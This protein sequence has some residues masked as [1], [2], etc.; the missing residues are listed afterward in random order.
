MGTDDMETDQA[1]AA[2]IVPTPSVA[3]PTPVV[4]APAV[5]LSS[6]PRHQAAYQERWGHL[7][8]ILSGESP[9]GLHLQV[10]D[11]AVPIP[12]FSCHLLVLANS[13]RAWRGLKP[14]R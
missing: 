5:T 14:Q 1:A 6:E 8:Q 7:K 9:I 13:A 10:R 12:C 3:P 2:P 4:A 11:D